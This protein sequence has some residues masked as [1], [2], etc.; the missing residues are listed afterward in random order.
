[1]NLDWKNIDR[2]LMGE[3]WTGAQIGAHLRMLCDQIGER[4]SSSKGEWKAVNYLCKKLTEAG[5]DQAGLE[6]FELDTWEWSRAEGQVVENGQPIDLLPFNRCPPFSLQAPIVNV[7]YGTPRE[8]EQARDRLRGGIAVIFLGFEPFTAPLPHSQRLQWLAAEGAAAAVVIDNKSGRRM[9]YHSASDWRDPD[10]REHPLPTVTT[11]REHGT[12]LRQLAEEGKQLK[13]EV[14]SRFYTAQSHNVAGEIRGTRWPDEHLLLGG[15][16]DTV[17]GTSGGNDNASGTIAVLE[18]ARVLAGLRAETGTAPGRTIRFVTFSAEEQKFQGSTA[19]VERHYGPEKP[20]R[21]TLSLD[22]LSTGHFKGIALGFP[23]LRE[24]IQRQFDSMG[25]GLQC[26]VMAQLDNT[27]DH[28]PF[29]RAG[30]D[31]AHLWRWRFYGRHADSEFHHEP[32]DTADKVDIRELKEYVGQLARL[33]LRLSH[34][35]PEEWPKNP[36]APEQVQKRLEEERG[37]VIRVF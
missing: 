9:E 16:H 37:T 6:E 3:A 34:V 8:I 11:S 20:T 10:L 13:L 18:A 32:A 12:L 36:V 4:W 22:E 28:F 31:A 7:G 15:H 14:E 1:M 17:Y 30:L 35:P 21:L 33:L 2:W 29:L 19:Y 5:V 26:H 27:S 23:H 24:L 25:D